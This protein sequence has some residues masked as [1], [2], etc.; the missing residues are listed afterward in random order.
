MLHIKYILGPYGHLTIYYIYSD[1]LPDCLQK[2]LLT[3]LK[4]SM[5]IVFGY[6]TVDTCFFNLISVVG[7]N[8][9]G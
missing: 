9:T 6:L 7:A 8:P 4:H 5:P 3:T 1:V 2:R